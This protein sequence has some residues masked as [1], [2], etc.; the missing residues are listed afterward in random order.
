MIH[1]ITP[2]T[3]LIVNLS[4]ANT[5]PSWQVPTYGRAIFNSI[6]LTNFKFQF[7]I[8]I[9]DLPIAVY[10]D[11]THTIRSV[12]PAPVFYYPTVA[13]EYP[14]TFYLLCYLLS[15]VQHQQKYYDAIG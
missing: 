10:I 12:S 1:L 3:K 7:L 6:I 8:L 5:N 9:Y 13:Y 11:H 14:H 15:I 2:Y 4:H